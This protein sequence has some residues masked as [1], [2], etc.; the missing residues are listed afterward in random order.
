MLM[1]IIRE[2]T[3]IKYFLFLSTD[4]Q[5]KRMFAISLFLYV[6]SNLFL[7]D[8]VSH[9][10]SSRSDLT[11]SFWVFLW[12]VNFCGFL[13]NFSVYLLNVN[14]NLGLS[15]NKLYKY[16]IYESLC[17]ETKTDFSISDDN[18]VIERVNMNDKLPHQIESLYVLSKEKLTLTHIFGRF[19]LRVKIYPVNLPI[20][21]LLRSDCSKFKKWLLYFFQ[22][23]YFQNC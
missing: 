3:L 6:T 15:S 20:S 12:R 9:K 21:K 23:F 11:S 17:I 18:E 19:F 5:K 13:L 8:C 10:L 4:F 16:W 7:G 14:F 1:N 2:P 22:K